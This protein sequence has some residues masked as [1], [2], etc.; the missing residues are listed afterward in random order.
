MLASPVLLITESPFPH[1]FPVQVLKS[2]IS[3]RIPDLLMESG[4]RPCSLAQSVIIAMD[5]S[6]PVGP[7]SDRD[8]SVHVCPC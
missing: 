1:I 7:P 2:P 4:L 5:V 8:S 6:Q 3:P